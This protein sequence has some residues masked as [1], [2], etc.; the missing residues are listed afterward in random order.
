[1]RALP[2][3]TVGAVFRT[4]GE[5]PLLARGDLREQ[6]RQ[7]ALHL[8]FETSEFLYERIQLFDAIAFLLLHENRCDIHSCS[9]APSSGVAQPTLGRQRMAASS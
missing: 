2:K 6:G 4:L 1:M 9:P 5:E 3:W 8:A 7:L